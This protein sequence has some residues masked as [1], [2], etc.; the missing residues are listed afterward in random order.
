MKSSLERAEEV[1]AN[2]TSA[3]MF[4]KDGQPNDP[5]AVLKNLIAKAIDEAVAEATA[6]SKKSNVPKK[7]KYEMVMEAVARKKGQRIG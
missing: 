2:Y 6:A 1:V 4:T 5:E 7:S 3:A